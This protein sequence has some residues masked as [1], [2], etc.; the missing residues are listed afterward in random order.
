MQRGEL[1]YLLEKKIGRARRLI[2]VTERKM[3][4]RGADEEDRVMRAMGQNATIVSFHRQVW[5]HIMCRLYN[6]LP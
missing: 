6:V 4:E 3:R 2:V 5:H 1:E